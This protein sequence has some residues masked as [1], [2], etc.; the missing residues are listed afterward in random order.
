MTDIASLGLACEFRHVLQ[1]GDFGAAGIATTPYITIQ[2][3][4]FAVIGLCPEVVLLGFAVAQRIAE[5]VGLSE[6]VLHAGSEEIA[7][8]FA[9]ISVNQ[10]I[11]VFTAVAIG[12]AYVAAAREGR[13]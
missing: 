6:L 1:G 4:A 8:F 3:I 10:S 13:D 11:P 12:R 7:F 2:H 5:L 9:E